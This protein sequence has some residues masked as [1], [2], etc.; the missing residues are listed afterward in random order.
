MKKIGHPA[1]TSSPLPKSV[2]FASGRECKHSRLHTH[3]PVNPI[4][5]G[6]IP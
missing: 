2:V 1:A 5:F 3:V 6:V 4:A